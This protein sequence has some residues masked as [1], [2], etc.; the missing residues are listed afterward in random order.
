MSRPWLQDEVDGPRNLSIFS[1]YLQEIIGAD[2]TAKLRHK[3]M[4]AMLA[5][6]GATQCPKCHESWMHEPGKVDYK[7]K[8]DKG[9]PLTK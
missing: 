8:D 3:F 1:P 5:K 7:L 9:T 4:V 6:M 2:A